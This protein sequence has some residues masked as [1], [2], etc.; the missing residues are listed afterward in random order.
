MARSDLPLLVATALLGIT[1]NQI[2]FVYSLT[3]TS[4]S[5]VAL[6]GATGPIITALLATAVGLERLGTRHWLSV[7]TGPS[8]I[9][10]GVPL[11]ATSWSHPCPT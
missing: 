8:G 3:N 10:S 4:A 11:C 6:L 2:R 5:D 7:G 9:V 1:L